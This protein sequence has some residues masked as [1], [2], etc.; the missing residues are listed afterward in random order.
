M[1]LSRQRK[2]QRLT[3][4]WD[5]F[6]IVLA[7]KGAVWIRI[8][9]NP[10]FRIHFE[11]PQLENLV[12]PLG[13][14]L[15]LWIGA[16]AWLRLYRLQRRTL[17]LSLVTQVM[18]ALIL[19]MVL[20]IVVIFF[21]RDFGRDFS[22]SFVLFTALLGVVLMM[23]GRI[24][25]AL[26]LRWAVRFGR[27]R[28]RILLVGCGRGVRT[29]IRKLEQDKHQS[30]HLCGVVAT[31]NGNGS[32]VLGNPVPVLGELGNLAALINSQ[33]VDRVIAV[34]E[35]LTHEELHRCISI[36]NKMG[37]PLNHTAGL[38]A[39][40]A[41]RIE[42]TEIGG[43]L[44]VEVQGLEFTRFQHLVKRC[45]DF[46]AASILL[47]LLSPLFIVLALLI[48]LSSFGPVFFVAPRVG[49]GGR[50][51]PC[52]KFRS[53]EFDAESRRKHLGKWNER[54]GHLFK[55]SSDPRVTHLGRW[56]RR[57]SID[58]LPQLINVL[59]GEMSLVGPRPLPARDLDG[60]GLSR[61]YRFWAKERSKVRPGITGLWQVS[62]RSDLQFDRMVRL[63]VAYVR[64][65]SV[66][67]DLQILFRTIP[68]VWAGRGAC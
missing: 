24:L 66:W 29:L 1:T 40:V 19:V 61:G 50:Y 8:L 33:G 47:L 35:E 38:L 68:A 3:L 11:E 36:C 31:A 28:E 9:L 48:P 55:I 32:K 63:D 58:E 18:E 4:L 5:L 67:L 51:F 41:K 26:L 27:G 62:G 20:T 54:G 14:V 45:F 15:L 10:F 23:A 53:M 56:I 59:R 46:L 16:S 49:R 25:L 13:V 30:I 52:F 21:I 17:F 22:R 64:T 65:W 12:P 44:L 6:A 60:D 43:A 7:Y 39:V 42:M 34:E 57:F 2:I 37:V